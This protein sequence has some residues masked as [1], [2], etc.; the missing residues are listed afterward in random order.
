M[1]M[2]LLSGNEFGALRSIHLI[3]S[4]TKSLAMKCSTHPVRC[5]ALHASD[6]IVLERVAF[7]SSILLEEPLGLRPLDSRDS[8]SSSNSSSSSHC[9]LDQFAA[10]EME[11]RALDEQVPS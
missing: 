4:I 3:E 8:K 10:M 5:I 11:A 7:L 9:P 1:T 2:I 6:L